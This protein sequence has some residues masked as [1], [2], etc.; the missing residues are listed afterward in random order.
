MSCLAAEI[1][2]PD[3]LRRPGH[4]KQKSGML[5]AGTQGF[6]NRETRT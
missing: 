5:F 2:F 1:S 6:T 3:K 4:P